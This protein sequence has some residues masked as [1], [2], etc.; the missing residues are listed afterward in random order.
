V[1]AGRELTELALRDP[2][3][4]IGYLMPDATWRT[5]PL[6]S[7]EVFPAPVAGTLQNPTNVSTDLRQL[8]DSFECEACGG[9]GLQP[10]TSRTAASR[11]VRCAE[12]RGS[13]SPR[14]PSAKP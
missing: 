12:G 5:W 2:M 1:V 14:T 8:L 9:T 13:E 3:K 7:P 11:P 10:A 6:G 4:A